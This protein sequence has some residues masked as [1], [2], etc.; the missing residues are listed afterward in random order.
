[1]SLM[2]SIIFNNVMKSKKT[3][4]AGAVDYEKR[5]RNEVEQVRFVRVPKC[6]RVQNGTMNGVPVEKLVKKGNPTDKIIYY[7]HGG[8]FV[9]GSSFVRRNLTT[10]MAKKFGLNVISVDYRLAPEHPFPAAPEDC[11]KVYEK[12]IQ[13]YDSNNIVV[14][15]ESAGGNLV[16]SLLLQIKE[17]DLPYP[18]GTFA[19]SPTVQYD[20]EFGSYRYN[21]N[22][23][24]CLENLS[25][26]VCNTYLKNLDK[27]QIQNPM[28]APYYGDYTGCTPVYLYVSNAEVLLDDSL[29]MYEKLK[30]EGVETTLYRR[31]G[32]MHAWM[33]IPM[34][35]ESKADL[36]L[37]SQDMQKV[38]YK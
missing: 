13:K 27:N 29:I 22:T 4:I 26:E 15:G 28:A 25:E 16:L 19:M 20:R 11:L 21:R 3:Y 7:I 9:T 8:G 30:A 10:Y 5:R 1:M 32:M 18:A 33:I 24:C 36:K 14:A 31:D 2:H 23:E 35:R 37:L 6:I 12:L 38:L 34:F 17:K